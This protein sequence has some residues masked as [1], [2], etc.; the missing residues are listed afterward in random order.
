MRTKVKNTTNEPKTIYIV[1]REEV[2]LEPG[3]EIEFD[4]DVELK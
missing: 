4:G 3:E 1:T 2:V